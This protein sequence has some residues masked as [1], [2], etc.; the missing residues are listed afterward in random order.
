[1]L[2]GLYPIIYAVV[3]SFQN[4]QLGISATWNGFDNY[5]RAFHDSTFWLGLRNVLLLMGVVLPCQLAFGFVIASIMHAKLGKRTGTLAGI[6]Y[7]P[8]PAPGPA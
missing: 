7:L 3:L 5:L 6:Y 2:F 8:A 1:M 4:Y